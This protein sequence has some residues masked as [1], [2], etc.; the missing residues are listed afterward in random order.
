M[1]YHVYILTTRKNTVLYTGMTGDLMQRVWQHKQG[2]VKGFTKD[3]SVN[4][5]V[6]MEEYA[7]SREAIH[8]EKC[9][10]EWKRDWKIQL[11][12][13]ANPEWLDLY[14]MQEPGPGL[15]RD[16]NGLEE[17]RKAVSG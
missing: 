2:L 5:L 6:Y 7:D 12:E 13:K 14:A 8:R 3:Y 17:C 4:K 16:D 1:P 11:I 9:I 10:K 15:R